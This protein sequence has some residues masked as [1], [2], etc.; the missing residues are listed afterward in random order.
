[1][2]LL[3]NPI[4]TIYRGVKVSLPELL[5][6]MVREEVRGLSGVASA[7]T[8][9][10]AHVLSAAKRIGPLDSGPRGTADG[11]GRLEGKPEWIDARPC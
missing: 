7:P 3:Q 9:C 8:S 4:L 5:A 10:V 1:M 11:C 2:N 6:A